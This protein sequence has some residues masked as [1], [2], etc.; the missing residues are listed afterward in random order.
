MTMATGDYAE[1]NGARLY[2]EA[3]G[4]GD[5]LVLLHAGIADCGMWD[6]VFA[7]LAERFRV[8]RYDRR[9]YGR[10]LMPVG[11]YAHINDLAG[12]LDHLGIASAHLIGC[13][14]GGRVTLEFALAHPARVRS[15]VLSGTGIRGYEVSDVV[16]TYA[17]QNDE[18]FM[19]GDIA[20][21]TEL[22]MRMWVIGARRRAEALAAGKQFTLAL[23][24]R[25]PD[26]RAFGDYLTEHLDRFYEEFRQRS[27]QQTNGE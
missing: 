9:G 3:A 23:K 18:A 25:G 5:P 20:L 2:Y 22:D 17:E 1:I 6:E 7:A 27:D 21:A 16:T 8:I 24:A 19:A 14:D 10:S 11:D 13:S 15:L 4:N 12:L 26:A